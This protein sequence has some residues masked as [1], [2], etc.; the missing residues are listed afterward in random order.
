MDNWKEQAERMIERTDGGK[1]PKYALIDSVEQLIE[2]HL[3]FFGYKHKIFTPSC[4]P[5]EG[6]EYAK[7]RLKMAIDRLEE[8]EG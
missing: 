3:N 8:W 7:L 4:D 5:S 1:H 6:I 2:E